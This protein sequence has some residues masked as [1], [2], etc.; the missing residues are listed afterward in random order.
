MNI[1]FLEICLMI[2]LILLS[3]LF[4]G[5]TLGLLSIDPLNLDIIIENQSEEAKYAKAIPI[6]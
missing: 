6:L 3:G 4:S 5:L 1:T 2:I